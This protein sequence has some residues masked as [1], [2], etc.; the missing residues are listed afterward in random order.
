MMTQVRKPA[1]TPN[2]IPPLAAPAPLPEAPKPTERAAVS[3]LQT[4]DSTRLVLYFAL[5]LIVGGAGG[6]VVWDQWQAANGAALAGAA[7]ALAIFSSFYGFDMYILS[8]YAHRRLEVHASTYL[9]ETANA[10]NAVQQSQIEELWEFAL[11]LEE[12]INLLRTIEVRDVKGVRFVPKTDQVDLAI[13]AWMAGSVFD[14]G[15]QLVGAAKNGQLKAAF[16]FKGEG[17]DASP[18]A[19][20]GY[21]RLRAAG[22]VGWNGTNYTWVGPALQSQALNLLASVGSRVAGDDGE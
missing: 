12:Q 8:G 1:A 11:G 16:P 18:Q 22:L 21:R 10:V 6:F 2:Y 4:T 17:A 13:R 7:L 20:A 3:L 15:G 14:A 9:A 19:K 5:A